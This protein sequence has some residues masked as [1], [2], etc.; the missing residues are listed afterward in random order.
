M[1]TARVWTAGTL[2]QQLG[3]ELRGSDDV[4]ITHVAPLAQA[5][6]GGLA[7]V[8]SRK[9][10]GQLA[11]TRASAILLARGLEIEPP[12]Q[13]PTLLV[14]DADLALSSAL[15]LL[16]PPPQTVP[17]GVHPSAVVAETA[18]IDPSAG[19]G[20]QVTVGERVRI[21]PRSQI[22]AGAR[23]GDDVSIGADCVIWQNVVIRERCQLA[24]RV[25]LHPNV[26]IGA[27]GFG[28]LFRDGKHHHIPQIGHV[29]LEDD[30]EIGANSAVD[31]AR[32]G[33]TRI[34]RGT[35]IDNLVQI[36]HNCD[37]GEDCVI[38]AQC[39]ISGST[40][41]GRH[42]VLGGQVGVVDHI[43]IGDRVQVAAKSGVYN[44]LAPDTKRRGNPC[45][46][47]VSYGRQQ[48]SVRRL[49]ALLQQVREL[50]KRVEE[51]ESAK[52]H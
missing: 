17:A 25:V 49:P 48:V 23:V 12:D 21:G 1:S 37:I 27:D 45:T 51:L 7:W 35:K 18:E 30:V 31:R 39:G 40:R 22:H 36:G 5:E 14:D 6:R 19:I 34:R 41:L 32:S 3:A 13:L 42:V 52:D 50:A 16:G 8:S 4:L 20:P 44:D 46:D 2:A 11:E 28:Y 9:Y 43:T 10:A 38:V 29:V 47:M 24:D 33:V 15:A 26:T